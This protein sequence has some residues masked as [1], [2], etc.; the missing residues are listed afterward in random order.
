MKWF[1]RKSQVPQLTKS[2]W[3]AVLE[4]RNY[5]VLKET[6][7]YCALPFD[8]RPGHVFESVT[9]LDIWLDTAIEEGWLGDSEAQD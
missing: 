1:K 6:E 8:Q 2:F 5:L 7:N 3:C 9:V 4:A